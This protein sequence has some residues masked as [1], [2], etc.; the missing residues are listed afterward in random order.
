MH[1]VDYCQSLASTLGLRPLL[2]HSRQE[3]AVELLDHLNRKLP[4]KCGE[5]GGWK[6]DKAHSILHKVRE[7]IMWGNSDNTNCQ[8]VCPKWE[9]ELYRGIMCASCHPFNI[10]GHHFTWLPP[11]RPLPSPT[12]PRPAA[13]AAAAAGWLQG[14]ATSAAANPCAVHYEHMK[15]V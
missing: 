2:S 1:G 12:E 13:A 10:R 4:D 15:L 9:S 11:C 5:K 8:L 14:P 6:F 3:M 7:I